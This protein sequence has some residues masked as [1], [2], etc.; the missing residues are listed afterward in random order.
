MTNIPMPNSVAD[1][2]MAELRRGGPFAERALADIV[3]TDAETL[4]AALWHAEQDRLVWRRRMDGLWWYGLAER[5]GQEELPAPQPPAPPLPGSAAER[6]V[7]YL[8]QHGQMKVA[9]LAQGLM[10]HRCGLKRYLQPHIDSG[11]VQREMR[12]GAYWVWVGDGKPA[13]EVQG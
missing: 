3:D 10:V 8:R 5:F 11:F 7:A 13:A 12:G 9:A 1:R 4:R 2:A 6:A